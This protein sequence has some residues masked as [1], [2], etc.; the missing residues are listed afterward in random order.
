MEGVEDA[1][2]LTEIA[3]LFFCFDAGIASSLQARIGKRNL[4]GGCFIRFTF[5]ATITF[6]LLAQ[7]KSS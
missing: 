7:S 1:V 3:I 6:L 5:W 2:P 4:S